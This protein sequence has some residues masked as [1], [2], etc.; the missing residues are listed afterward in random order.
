MLAEGR[1]AWEPKPSPSPIGRWF[2]PF[3]IKPRSNKQP[4]W[5][6]GALHGRANLQYVP[7]GGGGGGDLRAAP[8]E[9]WR[10]KSTSFADG[11]VD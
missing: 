2:D 3:L 11:E 7:L 9:H 10:A 4:E 5:P 6:L 1:L 8:G